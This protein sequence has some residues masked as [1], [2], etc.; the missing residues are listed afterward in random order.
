MGLSWVRP[1]AGADGE[2]EDL[3]ESLRST[4]G[5]EQKPGEGPAKEGKE[6]LPIR[7]GGTVRDGS[8][9]DLRAAGNDLIGN[10]LSPGPEEAGLLAFFVFLIGSTACVCCPPGIVASML[11]RFT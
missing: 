4:L 11:A 1:H 5:I 7:M 3:L 6:F 8:L 10:F 9:G 2:S